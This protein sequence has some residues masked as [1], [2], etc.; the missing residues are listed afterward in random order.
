MPAP[1]RYAYVPDQLRE[2]AVQAKRRGLEFD[3]WWNEAL[4][5][6]VCK[7]CGTET[8]L[9]RC[10]RVV[11]WVD[12]DGFGV[13]S[14]VECNWK[15]RGPAPPTFANRRGASA[16]AVLWPTDAIERR[17]W[18]AG[19]DAAREAWR[20]AYEGRPAKRRHDA[21]KK[22]MDALQFIDPEGNEPSVA[23]A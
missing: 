15:T 16:Y 23:V 13:L 18:L 21:V 4:P 12:Q 3:A 11:G 20:D 5:V 7:Q 2:L 1:A 8:L 6:R 22:L 14:P 9:T 17:A 19:V 10:P